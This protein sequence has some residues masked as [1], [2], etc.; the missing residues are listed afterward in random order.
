MTPE[1]TL[2][3]MNKKIHWIFCLYEPTNR[4]NILASPNKVYDAIHSN[5]GII[6]NS[7]LYISSKIKKENWGIVISEYEADLIDYENDLIN[8]KDNF[9]YSENFKRSYSFDQ[10]KNFY[11]KFKL[12][13]NK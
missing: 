6:T 5:C 9:F 1:E 3:F 2:D 11:S 10:Y 4:N 8:K 7:E 13:N 12:N